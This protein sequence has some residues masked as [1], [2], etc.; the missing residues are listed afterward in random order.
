MNSRLKVIKPL[1]VSLRKSAKTASSAL[2]VEP[3][4][5]SRRLLRPKITEVSLPL[6]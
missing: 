2:T 3:V 1:T 6:L 5:S 4:E